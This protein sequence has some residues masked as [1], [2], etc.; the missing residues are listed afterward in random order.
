MPAREAGGVAALEREHADQP[1]AH[2]P[3]AAPAGSARRAG[4]A[5]GSPGAARARRLRPL[6]ISARA[7]RGRSAGRCPSGRRAA[8][9][10]SRA[11]VPISPS[12][13][14]TSEPTPLS[15][16]AAAGDGE[17]PPPGLVDQQH[18]RVRR[19]RSPRPR[20]SSTAPSSACQ[21]AAPGSCATTAGAAPT[22][23]S[24]LSGGG[25]CLR[26]CG[27]S[28]GPSALRRL[29]R[30]VRGDLVDAPAPR[31]RRPPAAGRCRSCRCARRSRRCAPPS[32]RTSA[33]TSRSG[34]SV[35]SSA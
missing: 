10:R 19:S 33:P 5:A 8:M 24:R 1:L 32:C 28:G 16:V 30:Q 13:N 6:D 12:P 18:L 2:R 23:R 4:R 11:T 14:T 3:A 25:C 20:L 9:R 7:R 29:G 35:S 21:I 31:T 15:L 26:R 34:R 22:A 17:Q 27:R